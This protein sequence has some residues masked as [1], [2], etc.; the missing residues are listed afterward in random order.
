MSE[1]YVLIDVDCGVDD[2]WALLMLI[3]A[4]MEWKKF[5]ILGIS[6]VNGNTY[7]DNAVQNTLRLLETVGRTDVIYKLYINVYNYLHVF[8]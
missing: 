3:R 7:V 6:C 5:K 1:N 4:E 2:A 8:F